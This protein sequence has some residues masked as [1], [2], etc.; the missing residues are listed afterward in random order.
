VDKAIKMTLSSQRSVF[1]DPH[2]NEQDIDTFKLNPIAKSVFGVASVSFALCARHG[3]S[4]AGVTSI[5]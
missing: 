4:E 1:S 5:S 2:G 3:I